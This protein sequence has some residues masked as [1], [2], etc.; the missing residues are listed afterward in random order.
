MLALAAGVLALTGGVLAS[1][2]PVAAPAPQTL[3]TT[4]PVPP[5]TVKPATGARRAAAMAEG[6]HV[7]AGV[8]DYLWRHGCAPTSVGMIIGYYDG[9]GF[10]DLVPYDATTQTE[11]AQQMIASQRTAGHPGHYEDYSLPKEAD[12]GTILK[13]KSEAPAGDEHASDSVADFMHTS[14]SVDGLAYG[15]SFTDMAGPAFADYVHLRLPEAVATY[16]EYFYG[17]GGSSDLTLA[18]L[19]QEV[20]AGRPMVFFVDS[21]GD[22]V[23][24]HAV[25]AI[26]YRETSGYPEYACWDTWYQRIRWEPFTGTSTTAWG[27]WGAESFALS[28]V[29]DTRPPKTSVSGAGPGWSATPV[30]LSFSAAD[31][32]VGV[33]YTKTA[34]DSADWTPLSGSP[35]TVEVSGQGVHT[36]RY[37]SADVYGNVEATRSLAVRIDAKGP[38]TSA[39]ATS[40]LRGARAALRYRADD[41]TPR[42]RVRLAVRTLAGHQVAT[43]KIG[44][45]RTNS[46]HVAR[47]RCTL[48][49]G[50]YVVTVYAT[51]QAG[52]RQATAGSAHLTVR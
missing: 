19:Q 39:R 14:W 27:V 11:T 23:I 40:V 2:V 33:D 17:A 37:Y 46:L 35:G 28:G 13:D 1:A 44:V 9:H 49:R 15:W 29:G 24:D 47:W 38:V 6:E 31:T 21:S 34:V 5:P 32:G 43:L 3:T 42:A 36:V 26:G 51:D 52:N 4:G 10:P 25:A 30:T 12:G 45:R 20:D 22:G 50:V 48:P 41:L 16:Q 18:V 8:P 7:I